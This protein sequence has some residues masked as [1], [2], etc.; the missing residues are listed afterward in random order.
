MPSSEKNCSYLA[1]G[2]F[3]DEF[4]TAENLK[5]NIRWIHRSRKG[6]KFT[7]NGFGPLKN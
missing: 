6:K 5:F 7:E 2:L 1:I 4:S 3:D